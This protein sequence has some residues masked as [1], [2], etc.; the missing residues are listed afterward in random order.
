[1]DILSSDEMMHCVYGKEMFP[2]QANSHLE[3]APGHSSEEFY[4]KKTLYGLS[5]GIGCD[6][7]QA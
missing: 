5:V 1:M 7:A 3:A 4:N 2:L 6:R